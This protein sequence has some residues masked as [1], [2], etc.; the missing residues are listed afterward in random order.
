MR[1]KIL[2]GIWHQQFQSFLLCV[3]TRE[4]VAVWTFW[5]F[6]WCLILYLYLFVYLAHHRLIAQ[7]KNIYPPPPPP[8]FL[9]TWWSSGRCLVTWGRAG[10]LTLRQGS[11]T[12]SRSTT[13]HRTLHCTWGGPGRGV[14][15]VFK[16]D[17]YKVQMGRRA[18][19][20]S[21]FTFTILDPC[22]LLKTAL[23]VRQRDVDYVICQIHTDKRWGAQCRG[24]KT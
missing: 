22:P 1:V 10:R 3:L 19:F 17:V 15:S 11:L 2:G 16:K 12:C 20:S 13:H 7:T 5:L 21:A 18:P 14:H 23:V 6:Q 24:P 8:S 9:R 4:E